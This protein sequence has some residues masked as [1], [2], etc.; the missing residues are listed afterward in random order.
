MY[1]YSER[2]EAFRDQKVRLS[3]DFTEKLLAHRKANRDRLI[4]RLPNFINGVT[5]GESSFRPQ[6]SFAML[7][8]IQTRFTY[9]EYDIDDGLVL[10][11]HQLVDESGVELTALQ[12]KEKVRDALKDKRFNR[13]PEIHSNCVRVFYAEEDEERHHVDFPVYRKY[14]DADGNKVR[15]LAGENG[16]VASDPT[17]VNTWFHSLIEDRNQSISGWG[18]QTRHLVQLL[19]RFCRSRQTWDLPNGMK[20]T[21]LVAECQPPY[22]SRVD[23]AFRELVRNIKNRL[24]L[25]KVIRNLAHPDKPEITRTQNDQ[26]VADLQSRLMEA[27]DQLAALDEE[28]ANTPDSAR[29]VWDWIFKSDGFFKDF[30]SKQEEKR[31]SLLEKAALVGAVARTSGAGILGSIGM[32]NVAHGFYGEETMD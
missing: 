18:T 27:L 7:T 20:L 2:I 28:A 30:D 26:N 24:S 19:K 29:E 10:W 32:A 4:K 14:F 8:V 31:K 6:G 1:N 11:R 25:N 13:Q 22:D 9:E 23:V 17:Q 15:E 21:M 12:V 5:I 16:W 3:A